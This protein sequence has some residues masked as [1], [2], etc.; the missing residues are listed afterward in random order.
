MTTPSREGFLKV[1]IVAG[2]ASGDILGASL[3]D[4]LRRLY[5]A[6]QVEGIGGPRMIEAGCRSLFPMDRLSVMG[7]VEP[8]K[9]LPELLH[10]RST[11]K[12]HFL[13]HRPDV[14]IGIDS[15][16]FTLHIE[17][18]L[19]Q[20]GL[21]TVH[22]VSPSVW[23]WRQGRIH[24]IKQSVDLMLTLFPF[25]KTIYEQHHIRVA[26][27]GHPLA[28]EFPLESDKLV[29]RRALGID[30]S[31]TCVALL[32]GSRESEVKLMAPVF[33]E[34]AERCWQQKPNLQFLVP[35]A[36]AARHR[37]LQQ[38]LLGSK[39]PVT[40]YDGR[41]HEVMGASDV[42]LMASG[43][44][45]L[46]AML[47]KK[48]MVVAYRMAPL[49]YAI[50]S[51]LLKTPFVSLPNL[52]AQKMLVP[53]RLQA[54]ANAVQLSRDVLDALQDKKHAEQLQQEFVALHQQ[55]RCGAGARAAQAIQELLHAA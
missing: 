10:I 52:L 37:Q 43:T 34:T 36:N 6:L 12:K 2:E 22:Y 3:I 28:D 25:E 9:R 20:H 51:R 5:P 48:P 55:L 53:E 29:Y 47:L 1:G 50:I 42:V 49:S 13:Q 18:H 30:A 32:P 38:L 19:K 11:L 46:E 7:L 39:L 54:E 44:T 4:S 33:F 40:L 27:V 24:G 15:P 14:F 41:S 16:D 17:R 31:K 35:A 23:A 21:K 45:T 8:L 26:F